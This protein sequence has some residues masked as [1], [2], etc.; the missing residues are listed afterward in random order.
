MIVSF[1]LLPIGLLGVLLAPV[2]SIWLGITLLQ[3]ARTAPVPSTV[4]EVF[5]PAYEHK[6]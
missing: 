5:Q 6:G 4:F 1:V 2:W 3:E